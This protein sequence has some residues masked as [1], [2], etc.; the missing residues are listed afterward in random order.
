MQKYIDVIANVLKRFKF[1]TRHR[2]GLLHYVR[3]DDFFIVSV[4]PEDHSE[5]SRS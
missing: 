5:Q 1:A 2:S 4:R 3:N